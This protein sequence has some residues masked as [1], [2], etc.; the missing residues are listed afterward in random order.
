MLTDCNNWNIMEYKVINIT[1]AFKGKITTAGVLPIHS[2]G[3]KKILPKTAFLMSL[4]YISNNETFRQV[5]DRFNI[6][7]SSAYRTTKKIMTYLV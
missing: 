1:S 5:S 3:R 2:Y 7:K 4:W 6:S